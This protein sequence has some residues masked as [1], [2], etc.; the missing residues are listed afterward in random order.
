MIDVQHQE[1]VASIEIADLSPLNRA[2]IHLALQLRDAI[3]D[4]AD[5]DDVKVLVMSVKSSTFSPPISPDDMRLADQV[6]TRSRPQWHA[7]FCATTGLYQSLTYCKKTTVIAVHGSC[8]PV[9]S[10]WVLCSDYTV[11]A[12]DSRFESPFNCIP[13]SNLVI[14]ALT[15]RLNRAKSWMLGGEP[16]TADAAVNAGLVN[17][18]RPANA[19]LG[20]AQRMA[21]SA[22][23]TPLDGISSS[24]LLLEAFLDTQGVG[25][26]FDMAP[27]YADSMHLAQ[28]ST[29]VSK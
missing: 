20:H 29:G 10:M 23:R 16:W 7:A 12:E 13:E 18:K 8:G 3:R 21:I 2:D 9:G 28:P 22:A 24:K 25:Q 19:V 1:G 26:D 15:M 4:T 6:R 14:A 27:F 11:C 5:R 17:C